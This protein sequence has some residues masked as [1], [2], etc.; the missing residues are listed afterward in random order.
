MRIDC[1]LSPGCGS[2]EALKEN[3]VRALEAEKIHAEIGIHRV[4]DENAEELRR[5]GQVLEYKMQSPNILHC[6][7]IS[8]NPH[9]CSSRNQQD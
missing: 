5:R 9:D 6:V 1:S 8:S 3:I 7:V 4:S 2:E